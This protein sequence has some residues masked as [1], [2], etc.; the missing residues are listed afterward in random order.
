LALEL[1]KKGF[2]RTYVVK[3]GWDAMLQEGFPWIFEGKL[4]QI[5][6]KP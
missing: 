2:R 1:I 4:I 5:K 6:G 3:G